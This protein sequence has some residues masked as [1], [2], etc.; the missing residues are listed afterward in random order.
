MP[1]TAT[2]AQWQST[3]SKRS[4]NSVRIVC[5][6]WRHSHRHSR[7]TLLAKLFGKK[8]LDCVIKQKLIIHISSPAVFVF[9]T[10][11]NSRKQRQFSLAAFPFHNTSLTARF[12][13]L[14]LISNHLQN[15]IQIIS[16]LNKRKK[17]AIKSP[18][19]TMLVHFRCRR[20]LQLSLRVVYQ[21]RVTF[22]HTNDSGERNLL[23]MHQQQV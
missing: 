11:I 17:A 13:H 14:T 16:C 19:A 15:T 1:S 20:P 5:A 22:R 6:A 3:R 4:S 23:I 10:C 8:S 2:D 21:R 9:C 18:N 12:V 7:P